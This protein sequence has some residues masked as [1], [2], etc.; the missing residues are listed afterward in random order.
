MT[1]QG[2]LAGFA[3]MVSWGLADFIQS[4]PIRKIGTPKTLF[5]RNCLTLVFAGALALYCYLDGRITLGGVDFLVIMASSAAYIFGYYMFVKGFE[6][7]NISLVSPIGSSYSIITVVL[8][9]VFLHEKL[10]AVKLGAI[11]IMMMGVVLTATD[12]R[13]IRN[14]RSQKGLKEALLSMIGVG[15]AFFILGFAS[16]QVDIL[17]VFIFASLS[18]AVF[19]IILSLFKNGRVKKEDLNFKI[20]TIFIIHSLIVN[21]GWFFYIDG[22]GRHLVSLVTSLSALFPAVTVTLALI[23]YKEKLVTNQKAGIISILFGVYMISS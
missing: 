22:I 13:E 23:F 19:F 2:V 20:S 3:V 12:L 14:L 8:A 16:K 17:N 7:G 4:I 18:Q 6:I 9:F 10:P 5:L 1:N 21:T 15:I 11:F